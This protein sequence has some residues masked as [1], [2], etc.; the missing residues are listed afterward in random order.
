V[1]CPGLFLWEGAGVHRAQTEDL[2]EKSISLAKGAKSV[3]FFFDVLMLEML[4]RVRRNDS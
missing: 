3:K 2:Q 1:L 4:D